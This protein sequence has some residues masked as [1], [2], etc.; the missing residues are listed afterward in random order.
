[1]F[2]ANGW[3]GDPGCSGRY[4]RHQGV[5]TARAPT[6]YVGADLESAR[7]RTQGAPLRFHAV[8]LGEEFRQL[9]IAKCTPDALGHERIAVSIDDEQVRRA[10]RDARSFDHLRLLI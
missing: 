4:R 2:S 7:G 9:L 1:G 6:Q 3:P 10:D 8:E 5:E